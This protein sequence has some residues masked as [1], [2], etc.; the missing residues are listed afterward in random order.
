MLNHFEYRIPNYKLILNII[1]YVP[2]HIIYTYYFV[3]I[4][5]SH[6]IV[7]KFFI[8]KESLESLIPTFYL[9]D[10]TQIQ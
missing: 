2:V 8:I 1:I 10:E 4:R 9:I 3:T 6:K 5:Y 7:Y